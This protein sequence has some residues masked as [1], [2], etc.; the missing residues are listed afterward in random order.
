MLN[1][2]ELH[3]LAEAAEKDKEFAEKFTAAVKAKNADE[4]VRLAAGKGFNLK[5]E[6]FA[7]DGK[8]ELD[9][10]EFENVA[11]GKFNEHCHDFWD[12]FAC[13]LALFSE[14]WG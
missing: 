12:G 6:D 14:L 3:R 1:K 4:T 8:R 2:E 11:G 7:F 9:P 13:S 10:E 5:A